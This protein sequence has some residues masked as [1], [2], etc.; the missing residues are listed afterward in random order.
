MRNIEDILNPWSPSDIHVEELLRE[1]IIDLSCRL[2]DTYCLNKVA[3]LWEVA[4]PA[5][6]SEDFDEE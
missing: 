3:E 5:L 4:K 1:T 2:A 6:L